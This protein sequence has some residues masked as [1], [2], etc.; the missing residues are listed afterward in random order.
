MPHTLTEMSTI[1]ISRG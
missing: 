1:G